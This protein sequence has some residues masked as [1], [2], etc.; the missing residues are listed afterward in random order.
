MI[1]SVCERE[2]DSFIEDLRSEFVRPIEVSINALTRIRAM[3]LPAELQA[4]LAD[5]IR[6]GHRDMRE[7]LKGKSNCMEVAESFLALERNLTAAAE[8]RK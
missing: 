2:I 8:K 7:V 6:R 4:R 1:K 3:K 5:E